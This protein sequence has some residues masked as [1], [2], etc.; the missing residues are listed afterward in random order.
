[1]AEFDFIRPTDKPALLALST[2]EYLASARSVLHEM[3]YKVHNASD[4]EDYVNRFSQIQYQVTI[5]EERFACSAIEENIGLMRLQYLPM[6]LRRHSVALLIGESFQSLN[7][8]QA[9]QQS[10][11]AVIN[12]ADLPSLKQILQQVI[13]ENDLFLSVYRD[14]QQKM[15]LG[16]I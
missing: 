8:M 6:G 2:P 7:T 10:V 15:A 4:H 16:K 3:E 12:P 11:H 5:I 14:T 9:F 1:M 13:A